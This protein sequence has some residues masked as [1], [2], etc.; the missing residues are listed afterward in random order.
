M[1]L[2]CDTSGVYSLYDADDAGYAATTRVVESEAG[3]LLLPVILLAEIDYLLHSRLGADAAFQFLEAV[4]QG[5]FTL[6]PLLALDLARCRELLVQY[7]DLE[8]GLADATIVAAAE[9]LGLPRLLT[10]DQ[11]HFRAIHP[12]GFDHFVLLPADMA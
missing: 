11:R 3:P 5:D 8:I 1:A 9:R 12:R 7:R 10:Q 4:E 6:I 2:I